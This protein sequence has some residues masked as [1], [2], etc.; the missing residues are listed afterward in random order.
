LYDET[1]LKEELIKQSKSGYKILIWME[2]INGEE[3]IVYATYDSQI[4]SIINQAQKPVKA[5]KIIMYDPKTG[6][7]FV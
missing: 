2:L 3:Q 7:C 6:K 5:Y 1:K 4:Q